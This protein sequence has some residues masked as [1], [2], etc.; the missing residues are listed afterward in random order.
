MS[1]AFQQDLAVGSVDTVLWGCHSA[2]T[3]VVIVV[4][5]D[6]AAPSTTNPKWTMTGVLPNYQPL[7]GDVGAV[8]MVEAQFQNASPTGIVRATS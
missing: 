3:A 5:A 7:S 2:G 6:S 1:F 8:S 4:K